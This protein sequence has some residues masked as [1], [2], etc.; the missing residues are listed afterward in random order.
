MNCR[1]SKHWKSSVFSLFIALLKTTMLFVITALSD[2]NINMEK[3]M[4]VKKNLYLTRP[5]LKAELERCLSCKNQPCM[6][7]CPISCN[8]QEFIRLAK[9]GNFNEAAESILSRNPLGQTCGLV[10]PNN[11]CMKA[12]TRANIDFAI[13]IPKVQATILENYRLPA[14]DNSSVKASGKSVAVIGAGP[15]G[16][17]AAS[18]LAAYGHKVC[19]FEAKD[20]IGGAVNLIPEFRL[21]RDVIEKDWHSIAN[22]DFIS[23]K[24]NCK[25]DNPALLTE[26]G[27]DGVIVAAGEQN[28]AALRIEGEELCL[29]YTA[30][31]SAP[32]KY[33]TNG[34]VAV[35][36]GGNVAADCALTAVANG[37]EQVEM[38]VRRKIS[39]MR[40]SE[41]EHLELLAAN[42][43]ISSLTSPEKAEKKDG[44]ISLWVRKNYFHDGK[45]CAL[46]NSVVE[47]PGFDLI[48]KAVGS[49]AEKPENDERI[50]YAGD[51]K[52]GGSTV[53]EAAASGKTAAFLLMENFKK[54][55][56]KSA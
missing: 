1:R 22:K 9:E 41:T 25:I 54:S 45:L 12:C 37:A 33:K 26:K 19:L 8:P 34:K 7:A 44:S 47:L 28:P 14:A 3:K 55:K 32:E 20:K 53:V 48:I 42:V 39:D 56:T 2:R 31:L 18:V 23:V 24:F 51:C 43:N 30:Y 11:F 5:Q 50:I 35:I 38:F 10:C 40:I 17:T 27:F 21:P 13:N 4:P 29:S 36:G 6:K 46:P 16:L 49:F 15:A 52:T